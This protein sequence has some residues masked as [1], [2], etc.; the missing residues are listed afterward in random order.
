[1]NAPATNAST[2]P[3]TSFGDAMNA[4]NEIAHA[5]DDANNTVNGARVASKRSTTTLPTAPPKL[6]A[7]T[8]SSGEACAPKRSCAN[9]DVSATNV[10][11]SNEH[12][13]AANNHSNNQR[14]TRC[15]RSLPWSSSSTRVAGSTCVRGANAAI[16]AATTR[17]SAMSVVACAKPSAAIAS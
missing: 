11:S 10:S 7:A 9:N 12:S 5:I 15:V 16:A 14:V 17:T 6:N 13:V 8:S 3:A 1:M 4:V 2:T